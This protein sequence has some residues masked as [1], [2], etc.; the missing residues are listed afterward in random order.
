[1]VQLVNEGFV[2]LLI[3]HLYLFTNFVKDVEVREKIGTSLMIVTIAL[4]GVNLGLPI[5]LKSGLVSNK[6]KLKYM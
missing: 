3:Y 4:I 5:L 1:V 6:L 2:L